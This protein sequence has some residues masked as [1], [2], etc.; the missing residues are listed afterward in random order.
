MYYNHVGSDFT[1]RPSLNSRSKPFVRAW[2]AVRRGKH[3]YTKEKHQ[4]SIDAFTII[5]QPNTRQTWQ[6]APQPVTSSSADRTPSENGSITY[7]ST[8]RVSFPLP[9]FPQR[10]KQHQTLLLLQY[11]TLFLISYSVCTYYFLIFGP[12]PRRWRWLGPSRASPPRDPDRTPSRAP[13]RKGRY[14]MASDPCRR[15]LAL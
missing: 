5:A 3:T 12:P 14:S 15:I 13:V 1:R 8:L 6:A 11:Y 9:P 7:I 2:Q 10:K 4:T